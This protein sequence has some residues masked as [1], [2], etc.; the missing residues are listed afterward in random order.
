MDRSDSL[1]FPL[2][3]IS[4]TQYTVKQNADL[5]AAPFFMFSENLLGRI[6]LM[7]GPTEAHIKV[8]HIHF[9]IFGNC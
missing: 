1:D 9:E 6:A 5:S 3:L 2:F 4:L 7:Q 8:I